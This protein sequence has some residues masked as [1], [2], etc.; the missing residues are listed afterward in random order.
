MT[1]GVHWGMSHDMV[2]VGL[3]CV[4]ALTDSKHHGGII[5]LNRLDNMHVG[6]MHTT[7][8]LPFRL[9]PG[10]LPPLQRALRALGSLGSYKY[11][12]VTR[13]C[14]HVF[15]DLTHGV[16]WSP[17]VVLF[18]ALVYSGLA[19]VLLVVLVVTLCT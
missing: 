18:T 10:A 7:V 11:N 4:V 13:N 2:Y 8:I 6:V 16:P 5:R 3:G 12:A 14:Q 17:A 9:G 19:L 1:M 15:R